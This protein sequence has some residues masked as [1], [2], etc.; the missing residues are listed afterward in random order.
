MEIKHVTIPETR[1]RFF[2]FV[3]PPSLSRTIAGREE[4]HHEIARKLQKTNPDKWAKAKE[5]AENTRSRGE[6]MIELVEG[7]EGK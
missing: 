7:A 2:P 4:F 3:H 5:K 6:R 1:T